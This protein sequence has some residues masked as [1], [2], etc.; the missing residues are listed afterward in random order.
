MV[1]NERPFDQVPWNRGS[2]DGDDGGRTEGTSRGEPGT[3]KSEPL[4]L[5]WKLRSRQEEGRVTEKRELK[6]RGAKVHP[7]SGAGRIKFDGS[8]E[9]SIIE[10]KDATSSFTIKKSLISSLYK[11]ASRQGKQGVL[12]IKM[13]EFLIEARITRSLVDSKDD[14]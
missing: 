6:K 13:G 5:P 7:N 11:D 2:T 14:D 9:E 8:D 1:D 4:D 3:D 12:L 10:V